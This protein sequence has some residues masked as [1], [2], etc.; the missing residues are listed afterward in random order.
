M[1]WAD[2]PPSDIKAHMVRASLFLVVASCFVA[3]RSARGE[4]PPRFEQQLDASIGLGGTFVPQISYQLH[5]RILGNHS[6]L[7]VGAGVR[8][9]GTSGSDWRLASE[10]APRDNFLDGDPDVDAVFPED[11][12]I[13]SLNL[14]LYIRFAFLDRWEVGANTDLVGW[15]FGRRTSGN[16]VRGET[17]EVIPIADIDAKPLSIFPVSGSYNT[18]MGWVGFYVTDDLMVRAGF[19]FSDYKY[20]IPE[21]RVPDAR[22]DTFERI[23]PMGLLGLTYA[24]R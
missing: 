23:Y 22:R 2:E 10:N 7:Y 4:P 5:V 9:F 12:L 21:D 17:Q 19:L 16:F 8:L 6:R 20:E 15:S 24:L 13:G 1:H 11:V 3:P 14:G 18:E